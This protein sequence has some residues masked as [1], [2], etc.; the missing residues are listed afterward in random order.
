MFKKFRNLVFIV[1][2]TIFTVACVKNPT[3]LELV[4]KTT[5]DLNKD[6]D[7][8]SSPLMLTFYELESAEKFS[9]FDYWTLLEKSGE[10]L[11]DDLV[12]Q[13]KHIALTQQKQN[14]KVSFG[15]KTKY[16]GIVANFRIIDNDYIWKDVIELKKGSYNYGEFEIRK[17]NMERVK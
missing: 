2:L 3:H 14:H 13:S 5:E 7:G 17:F 9:K 1:F 15:D 16:L 11:K 12:S 8:R 10:N 4:L 6:V